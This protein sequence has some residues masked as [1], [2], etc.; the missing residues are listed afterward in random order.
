MR[1]PSHSQLSRGSPNNQQASYLLVVSRLNPPQIDSRPL[2]KR[3]D[4][5]RDGGHLVVTLSGTGARWTQRQRVLNSYRYKDTQPEI[6][7][8]HFIM[9]SLALVATFLL[10]A[11]VSGAPRCEDSKLD[12]AY[13]DATTGVCQ[14]SYD[15]MMYCRRTCGLC[16]GKGL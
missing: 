4:K 2:V 12:C 1:P 15:A 10:A 8:L 11:S 6:K 5:V 16:A 13:L 14:D 9:K 7:H 3:P